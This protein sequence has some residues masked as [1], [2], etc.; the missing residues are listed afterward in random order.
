MQ[1]SS[2]VYEAPH[3]PSIPL[4]CKILS[5]WEI[6]HYGGLE[7]SNGSLPISLT[8]AFFKREVIANMGTH[9]WKAMPVNEHVLQ[10]SI[11]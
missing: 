7:V 2:S 6:S 8:M 9:E 5:S 3:A 1:I 11:L 4:T 10:L